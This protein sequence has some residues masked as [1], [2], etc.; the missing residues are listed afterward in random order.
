MPLETQQRVAL[1]PAPAFASADAPAPAFPS[2]TAPA[3]A[4]AQVPAPVM[5]PP[6]L[7]V[8]PVLQ[9]FARAPVPGQCKTRLIRAVGTAAAAAEL[10]QRLVRHCLRA[11]DAWQ[12]ATP[13]ARV[14][15]WCAPDIDHPFFAA[16]ARDFNIALKPQTGTDLG[17]RMWLALCG[18]LVRGERPVLIGTDC[19]WLT[20]DSISAAF[21]ALDGAAA[22][23]APAHDGG[24]V[25]TGLARAMPE[26]F[27][28]IPWS[29]G[30]VMTAT[31]QAASRLNRVGR[32]AR[33]AELP[34][35]H[36]I[37]T[38]ADLARL[39]RDPQLA[40]LLEGLTP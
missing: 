9:V 37:D 17:A 10:H 14:E 15:L 19:P 1:A 3:A 39:Q 33:L 4:Q 22:V 29:T 16:C 13:D 12:R 6:S 32:P 23:F 25:L 30:N 34:A 35:L 7:P 40:H 36:D 2:A 31:R 20:G 21:A 28:G 27:A 38:P 8:L 11:A 5:V 24:Y 26:L 18:A